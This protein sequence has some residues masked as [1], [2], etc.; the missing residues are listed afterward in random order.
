MG[1]FQISDAYVWLHHVLGHEVMYWCSYVGKTYIY[2]EN[3][4]ARSTYSYKTRPLH[5]RKN[6]TFFLLLCT[7][8]FVLVKLNNAVCMYIVLRSIV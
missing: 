4:L 5:S 2:S 1:K 7:P 8:L 3:A 6:L